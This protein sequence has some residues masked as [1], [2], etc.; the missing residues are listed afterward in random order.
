MN[1]G[2]SAVATHP[3]VVATDVFRDYTSKMIKLVNIFMQRPESAAKKILK[4]FWNDTL[5]NGYYYN[6]N[7]Q[8]HALSDDVDKTLC[9][10]LI[11]QLKHKM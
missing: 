8:K 6:Q 10:D 3:G 2:Y 7:K 11:E 9:A 4:P 1:S 5:T